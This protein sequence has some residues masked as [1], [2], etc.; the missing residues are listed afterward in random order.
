MIEEYSYDFKTV[1]C[2]NGFELDPIFKDQVKP[3]VEGAHLMQYC[4]V[5]IERAI[6]C[7]NDQTCKAIHFNMKDCGYPNQDISCIKNT[8]GKFKAHACFKPRI[9]HSTNNVIVQK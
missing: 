7:K 4:E 3:Y 8:T 1:Y 2:P 5:V 6:R 9:L